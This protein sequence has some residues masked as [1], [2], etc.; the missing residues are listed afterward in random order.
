MKA[1]L[2]KALFSVNARV[3]LVRD[4]GNLAPG[5]IDPRL[6]MASAGTAPGPKGEK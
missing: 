3:Y 2:V 1:D 6:S 4:V 5:G